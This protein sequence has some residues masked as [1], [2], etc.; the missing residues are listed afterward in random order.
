MPSATEMK[1]LCAVLRDTPLIARVSEKLQ[2]CP[3]K[4]TIMAYGSYQPD[5]FLLPHNACAIAILIL[6]W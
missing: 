3:L 2:Q 6:D 5:H 1:Q 4:A